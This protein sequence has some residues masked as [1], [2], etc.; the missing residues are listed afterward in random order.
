MKMY[1]N[2]LTVFILFT[3]LIIFSRLQ[4]QEAIPVAGGNA[5]GSGGTS[6]YTIGQIFYTT[7]TR[8]TGSVTQGIQQPYE[9]SIMSEIEQTKD[10]N[11]ICMVYPNPTCNN[12]TL[13]IEDPN[14]FD[15]MYLLLDLNGGLIENKEVI[16]NK[17]TIIM[18]NRS[19][20]IY[21][22]RVYKGDGSSNNEIKTF[23]IIKQ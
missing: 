6:S 17:T 14:N 22:L 23:K 11:L 3:F 21:F 18:T 19:A 9:I 7:N 16:F 1:K 2:R 12:L 5:S 4:A 8:S 15:L 10:I 20:G 13:T